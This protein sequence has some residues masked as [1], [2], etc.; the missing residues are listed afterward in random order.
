MRYISKLNAPQQDVSKWKIFQTLYMMIGT[1]CFDGHW[2]LFLVPA[3][4]CKTQFIKIL[5]IVIVC[6]L[7]EYGAAKLIA[8][9]LCRKKKRRACKVFKVKSPLDRNFKG[10]WRMCGCDAQN[11]VC[12]LHVVEYFSPFFL[13]IYNIHII[14][15]I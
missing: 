8:L 12:I 3:V 6:V 13:Y 14:I 1:N 2:M 4:M 15:V 9:Y 7:Y 11:I 5:L 10:L